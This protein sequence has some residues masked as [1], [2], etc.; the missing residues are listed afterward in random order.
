MSTDWDG[1]LEDA[2]ELKPLHQMVQA[3][4]AAVRYG[5]CV[6]LLDGVDLLTETFGLSVQ[7]VI[8]IYYQKPSENKKRLQQC[9]HRLTLHCNFTGEGAKMVAECSTSPL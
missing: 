7:E 1:V 4:S 3:F 6:I 9:V 8:F 5:P 2:T